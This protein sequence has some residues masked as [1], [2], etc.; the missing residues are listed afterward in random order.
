MGNVS[1]PIAQQRKQEVLQMLAEGA[2]TKHIAQHLGITREALSRAMASDPDY[3]AAMREAL[4]ARMEQRE[5]ELESAQDGITLARARELLSHAR[6]RAER[7]NPNKYGAKQQAVAVQTD[8]P[9][10]IVVVSYGGD[11]PAIDNSAS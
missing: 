5:E 4:D 11:T 9:A 7:L 3:Q 10:K 8:G 6:W 1:V 2:L